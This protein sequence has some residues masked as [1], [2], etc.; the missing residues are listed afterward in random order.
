VKICHL[1]APRPAVYALA[2]PGLVSAVILALQG[3]DAASGSA[4]LLMLPLALSLV[5]RRRAPE[6]LIILGNTEL[7]ETLCRELRDS[8]PGDSNPH[9]FGIGPDPSGHEIDRRDL[10]QIV[11]RNYISRIVVAEPHMSEELIEFLIDCKLRG[12][13]VEQVTDSLE[14]VSHKIWLGGFRPELLAYSPAAPD[15]I[16]SVEAPVGPILREAIFTDRGGGFV[17]YDA[18]LVPGPLH[19]LDL[20]LGLLRQGKHDMARRLLV[21]PTLL[22]RAIAAGWADLRSPRNFVVDRKEEGQPW[23]DWLGA[24]VQ[25]RSGTQRW[26]FRFTLQEGHWQIRDWVA[27]EPPRA[28]ATRLAPPDSTGGR[29]P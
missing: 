8:A 22:D 29:K 10:D 17:V 13:A 16:L 1:T 6:T 2:L 7:G 24:R 25:G 15:S 3:Y 27:E 20:F 12:V 5:P 26:V 18:R 28:N 19:A 21:D 9:V 14:K 11:Q 4:L 23:P